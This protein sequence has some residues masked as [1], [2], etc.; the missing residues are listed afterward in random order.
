MAPTVVVPIRVV[1]DSGVRDRAPELIG[2]GMTAALDAALSRAARDIFADAMPAVATGPTF[3]WTGDGLAMLDE[4]HRSRVEEAIGDLIT[5]AS[6]RAGI[7]APGRRGAAA[8]P[9]ERPSEPYDPDRDLG[10]AYLVDSYNG[11]KTP[12]ARQVLGKSGTKGGGRRAATPRSAQRIPLRRFATHEEAC[13]GLRVPLLAAL[14]KA[15]RPIPFQGIFG[16]LT[17]GDPTDTLALFNGTVMEDGIRADHLYSDRYVFTGV[18]IGNDLQAEPP[19]FSG[20]VEPETQSFT[21]RRIGGPFST[22]N[23][24]AKFIASQR[25][26]KENVTKAYLDRVGKVVFSDCIIYKREDGALFLLR[27]NI[28]TDLIVVAYLSENV[29]L[30]GEDRDEAGGGGTGAERP[31]KTPVAGGA[32]PQASA[33]EGEECRCPVTLFEAGTHIEVATGTGRGVRVSL[34]PF[35]CEPDV[36]RLGEFGEALRTTMRRIA[37]SLDM[38][39]TDY[40][41]AASFAM[42]ALEVLIGRSLQAKTLGCGEPEKVTPVGDGNGDLGEANMT[43]GPSPALQALRTL[44]GAAELLDDLIDRITRTYMNN[45]RL[46][47][48]GKTCALGAPWV[49]HFLSRVVGPQGDMFQRLFADA[50]SVCLLQALEASKTM[51]GALLAER[52]EIEFQK[53]YPAM[54]GLLATAARLEELR[55]RLI[56]AEGRKIDAILPSGPFPN[57][58]DQIGRTVDRVPPPR[59]LNEARH[60]VEAK[61]STAYGAWRDVKD[62]LNSR[63]LDWGSDIAARA[64]VVGTV[65]YLP[66]GKV[67]IRDEAN[68]L[69]TREELE[70]A[71]ALRTG[72]A[73]QLSPLV[74][75]MRNLRG[76]YAAFTSGEEKARAYFRSVLESMQS[77]NSTAI[78]KVMD[79]DD[80]AV[81]VGHIVERK[82][83]AGYELQGIHRVAYRALEPGFSNKAYLDQGSQGKLRTIQVTAEFLVVVE[84]GVTITLGMIFAPLGLAAGAVFAVS[85]LQTALSHAALAEGLV[86]A[87]AVISAAEAEL[88][89]FFSMI[90]IALLIA[91]EL[92]QMA[93]AARVVASAR[94]EIKALVAKGGAGAAGTLGRGATQRVLDHLAVELGDSIVPKL[95]VQIGMAKLLP[96]IM[97]KLFEPLA[98]AAQKEAM[99]EGSFE[100]VLAQ[101]IEAKGTDAV[102]ALLKEIENEGFG[103]TPPQTGAAAPASPP[104]KPREP[105]AE[106]PVS[107]DNFIEGLGHPTYEI[108]LDEQGGGS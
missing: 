71:I 82:G 79:K 54:R 77:G 90:E 36:T 72:I 32:L 65:E 69:W 14:R 25:P 102:A 101:M 28:D 39:D 1:I 44:A 21:I 67:V 80:F 87:D 96:A 40:R 55:A 16:L 94:G 23:D 64:K 52:F 83:G 107:P 26:D 48:G 38:P 73:A 9:R 85:R 43:A 5:Q 41:Y 34:E 88:E 30:A 97:D 13:R 91:P 84:L 12:R 78:R 11:A 18:A 68:H 95:L 4:R 35:Q 57:I 19:K 100:T 20:L 98:A 76:T 27:R 47:G 108:R 7:A 46:D 58:V 92:P 24:A 93:R 89:L 70:S 50:C 51:I 3:T 62:H 33:S 103:E 42:G 6:R 66:D 45:L 22:I 75:H 59:S 53:V 15:G 8:G 61:L 29:H 74:K 31:K 49:G 105:P 106:K 63:I 56:A 81:E 104:A 60:A 2:D 37:A 99:L 17:G 10:D 86:D